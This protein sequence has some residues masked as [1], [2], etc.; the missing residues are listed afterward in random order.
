MMYLIY[1]R[2]YRAGGFTSLGSDPSQPPLAPYDPEFSNNIE[3]GW[4]QSWNNQRYRLNAN[5]FYTFVNSVQTPTLILPDAITV[6]RNAGKLNS[7]GA[8]LEFAASPV[9]GFELVLNG[10]LTDATY[11]ELTIPKDGQAIDFSGNKQIFTPAYTAMGV[12][13]YTYPISSQIRLSARV[14][15]RL[16]GKQYFDLANSI[17]QDAYSLLHAR[18]GATFG[19]A[20][21]YV[22]MR[23]IANTT[24]IAYGYDFGGVHLGNPRTIGI[25]ASIRL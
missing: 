2:G 16:L 20:D 10:G 19:K 17:S 13:Q 12:A 22:W 15:A 24:F 21:F 14:E 23:N 8:E 11:T 25:T 9:K 3:L 4:K 6:I 7:K 1:S 18:V 5:L